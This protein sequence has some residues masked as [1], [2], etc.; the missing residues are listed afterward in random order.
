MGQQQEA[1]LL[2]TWKLKTDVPGTTQWCQGKL[3]NKG[4]EEWKGG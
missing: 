1:V 4:R 2:L 3:R